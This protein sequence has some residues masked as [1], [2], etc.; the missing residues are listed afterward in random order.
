VS[1]GDAYGPIAVSP[2]ASRSGR[3]FRS[4]PR[5]QR[6]REGEGRRMTCFGALEFN[7]QRP[8]DRV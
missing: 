7:L 2:L 3:Y 5:Q 1:A 6:G 4:T 8:R